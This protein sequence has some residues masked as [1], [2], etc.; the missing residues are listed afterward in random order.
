MSGSAVGTSQLRALHR[1]ADECQS[2]GDDPHIWRR[3]FSQQLGRMIGADLVFCVE[4]AGCRSLHPVDLGVAAWGWENGFDQAGWARAMMEF[5]QN[6]FYS[7]GLRRYFQRFVAFD[8]V[9]HSRRDLISDTEWDDSFDYQVIHRTIGV[10]HVLWCF[11]SLPAVGDE[12]IGVI[13]T[14]EKNRRDFNPLDKAVLTEANALLAPLVGGPLARFSEP[15]PT[16]LPARTLQVLRC[17]LE[18]DGDKQ[19][20]ARLGISPLTVNVHTKAIFA[21]FHVSSRTELLARWIRQRRGIGGWAKSA[22]GL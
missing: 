12:Q 7:L 11:R 5:Q 13:A 22:P 18:G 4:T 20:A 6:P 2:L 9:A 10:D 17:L 16:D 3:H 21:H 14:R 1:L 8:G 15:S 19:I